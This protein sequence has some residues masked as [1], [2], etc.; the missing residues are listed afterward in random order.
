ML[1]STAVVA[2]EDQPVL[3]A[4]GQPKTTRLPLSHQPNRFLGLR[5]NDRFRS[6]ETSLVASWKFHALSGLGLTGTLPPT[7]PGARSIVK[8]T[9]ASEC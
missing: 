5:E 9:I 1:K 2:A 6:P 8:K 4:S 3:Q 7:W